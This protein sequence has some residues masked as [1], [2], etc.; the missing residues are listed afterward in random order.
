MRIWRIKSETFDELV[1]AKT[2]EE[3]IK[4]F[5]MVQWKL[6]QKDFANPGKEMVE[7]IEV[8]MIGDTI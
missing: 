6:A 4:K 1:S 2:V 3:A 7:P 5:K 8:E